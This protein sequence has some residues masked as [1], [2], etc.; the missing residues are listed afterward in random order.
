M[1]PILTA[2]ARA[3]TRWQFFFTLHLLGRDKLYKY[4]YLYHNRMA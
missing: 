3:A 1:A 4:I 2:P